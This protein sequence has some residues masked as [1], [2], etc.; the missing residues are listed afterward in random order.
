[1]TDSLACQMVETTI[2]YAQLDDQEKNQILALQQSILESVL[3]GTSPQDIIDKICHLEESLL[4]NSV[5]TV[6]LFDN[7]RNKLDIIAGPSLTQDAKDKFSSLQP[8]PGAGSCG[9]VIYRG[10]PV[11][12]SNTLEDPHWQDLRH[13]AQAYHLMAC[14][15]MPIRSANGGIIGTFALSSFESRSPSPFH[16]K[17]LE[18]GASIIGIVLDRREQIARQRL[19]AHIFNHTGESVLITDD[20][21]QTISINPVFTQ[22][23]GYTETD[24][25]GKPPSFLNS[26]KHDANYYAKMWQDL[27][28][29][30]YWQ[31]EILN[32]CQNGEIK[33]CLLGISVVRDTDSQIQHYIGIYSDISRYKQA[34]AEVDFLSRHDAMTRLPNRRLLRDRA[35]YALIVARETHSKLALLV[36]DIDHFKNINDSLGHQLGD[37]V[38]QDIVVRLQS[39]L[40]HNETLSRSSGDEF[41]I[42]LPNLRDT[43][44]IDQTLQNLQQCMSQAFVVSQQELL[45]S[46]STGIAIYPDDGDNFDSLLKAADIAMHR[47]KSIGRNSWSYFT[48]QM[49]TDAQERITL[50][51]QLHRALNE[52]QLHLH[53][54]PQLDLHS[55]KILGAEA[56]LRWT[57]PKLGTIP[58]GRFIPVAEESG[59][60]VAIGAWVLHEA[61][62]Q[63]AAWH[64]AGW[65]DL[66]ISVNLSAVQ[67][68]RG[69][70]IETVESALQTSGLAARFLELELTESIVMTH[71]DKVMST[72]HQL[73]QLGVQLSIDDFGTGYS[74]LSYLKRFPIDKLK[75]DQSFVRDM[76]A[77]SNDI[78]IVRAIIQMARNM[79]LKTIAEGVEEQAQLDVLRSEQCDEIQGYWLSRPISAEQFTGWLTQYDF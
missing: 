9:N 58:P 10:E 77:D 34:Q 13:L 39:I 35:E 19:Y 32:R 76:L 43:E 30:G 50:G 33:P 42:L 62:R 26:G 65:T 63:T 25:L 27:N 29:T 21:L 4:P 73:K 69:Q 22:M 49:N 72:V 68:N 57:H 59:Q 52:Q 38:L 46:L 45:I 55:G 41:L 8:G 51:N 54:Q 44:Q 17:L 71:A 40:Q 18:I 16:L 11:F 23:F 53:Y 3:D 74:S 2:D 67:F 75:I 61:C 20:K 70:L 7:K 79:H 48:E 12:V 5:G 56:L 36:L 60:I 1:M 64:A 37:T 15:S 14:W 78:A 24:V 6:M 31:D 66:H 47:A 28:A